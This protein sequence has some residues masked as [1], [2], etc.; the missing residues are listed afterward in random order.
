MHWTYIS[1][2]C[3]YDFILS[4][5]GNILFIWSMQLPEIIFSHKTKT[6]SQVSHFWRQ[7]IFAATAS[8]LSL[9]NASEEATEFERWR[10]ITK[11]ITAF[12]KNSHHSIFPDKKNGITFLCRFSEKF[13]SLKLVSL[14]RRK[15]LFLFFPFIPQR[16]QIKE[17]G[18]IVGKLIN[19]IQD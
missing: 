18:S 19:L 6:S 7:G 9:K 14:N 3:S 1:L 4:N 2:N 5:C 8:S 12:K 16:V 10:D 15:S 13:C 17:L 11:F